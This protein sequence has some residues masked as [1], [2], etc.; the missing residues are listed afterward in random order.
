MQRGA[1]PEGHSSGLAVLQNAPLPTT[2]HLCRRQV[3]K[4]EA[5]RCGAQTHH[6]DRVVQGQGSQ[7]G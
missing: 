2:I 3:C 7:E 6:V 1:L 4:R 5:L